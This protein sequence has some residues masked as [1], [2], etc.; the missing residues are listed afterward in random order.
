MQL[1]CTLNDLYLLI[2]G[3]LLGTAM[4]LKTTE[5]TRVNTRRQLLANASVL[6][7]SVAAVGVLPSLAYAQQV[8]TAGKEYRL[9][10]PVQATDNPGKVEVVEFFWYGC[11]HCYGLEPL[12]KDWVKKLPSDVAF[13]KVHVQFQE[14]KHQQLFFALQAMGKVEELTDK[15][16][17]DT[18]GKMADYLAPLGVKKDEFLKVFDS[19]GV[20]TAQSRATKMS[21]T[22]KVD[23][24]PA[25]AVNG[26]YYTA[27]AMAGN[28]SNAIKVVDYLI[29]VERK[30][31]KK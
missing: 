8:P 12:L 19:F 26:K 11:P 15:D 20:R 3:T 9:I 4:K 31:M 13:K 1:G 6:A 24:V 10:N 23:G 14:V 27:P 22:F 7:S 18:P 28:N 30:A 2:F 5:L 21:E 17:L 25:F 29:E 16:R